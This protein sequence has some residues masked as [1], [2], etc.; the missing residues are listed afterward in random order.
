MSFGARIER[1]DDHDLLRSLVFGPLDLESFEVTSGARPG[2]V[3][4]GT[5]THLPAGITPTGDDSHTSD[6]QE[7]HRD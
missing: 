5:L 2:E 1:L 3:T 6:L 7:L 4:E